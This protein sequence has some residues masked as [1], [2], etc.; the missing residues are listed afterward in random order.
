MSWSDLTYTAPI[1]I[2]IAIGIKI[3]L[4]VVLNRLIPPRTW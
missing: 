2:E 3:V 1:Q 4:A